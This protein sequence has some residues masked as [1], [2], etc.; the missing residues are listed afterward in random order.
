MRCWLGLDGGGTKLRLQ[1]KGEDGHT[2]SLVGLSS[3]PY[4][5]GGEV[6]QEHIAALVNEMLA[7]EHSSYDEVQAVVLGSAGMGRKQEQKDFS[8]F[9]EHLCP[10][11]VVHVTTD[12]EIFLVGALS[13]PSGFALIAGTGSIAI[14]RNYQG[15]IVRTGGY[16]WRIGDP[17]S[18]YGLADD[19]IRAALQSSEGLLPTTRLTE[20]VKGFFGLKEL[21]DIITL[22]ND[23]KTTKGSIALFGPEV[24]EYAEHGDAVAK[25]IVKKAANDL[26]RF[27]EATMHRLPPPWNAELALGGG[28]LSH[29]GIFLTLVKESIR[30]RCPNLTILNQARGSAEEGALALALTLPPHTKD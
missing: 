7:K 21:S 6:A 15:T 20:A 3:N 12:A 4:G 18:G 13:C 26:A 11:A 17:G 1:Y 23:E 29:E 25:D 9:L 22:K 30:Q 24:L 28:M 19:A 2:S 14:G 27:V 16:G 10:E 5:V 8:L